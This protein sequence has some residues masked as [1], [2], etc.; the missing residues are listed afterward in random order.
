MTP[1]GDGSLLLCLKELLGMSLWTQ[2]VCVKPLCTFDVGKCVVLSVHVMSVC[3]GISYTDAVL[4][5]ILIHWAITKN[6]IAIVLITLIL[7]MSRYQMLF[8]IL[9]LTRTSP[10]ILLN[11]IFIPF[12]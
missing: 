5:W 9:H 2:K 10:L 8:D 11:S 3:I 1:V 4:D 12:L 6:S 7:H